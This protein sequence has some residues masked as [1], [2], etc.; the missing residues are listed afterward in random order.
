[1]L[2]YTTGIDKGS[3]KSTVYIEDPIEGFNEYMRYKPFTI[4][5]KL[6][7]DTAKKLAEERLKVMRFYLEALKF[8]NEIDE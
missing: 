2:K 6:N 3:S 4:S 7:T 1:M 5:E 8:E